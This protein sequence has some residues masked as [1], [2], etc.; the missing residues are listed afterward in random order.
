MR[1]F[2]QN[3]K[4][5]LILACFLILVILLVMEVRSFNRFMDLYYITQLLDGETTLT[6]IA[7]VEISLELREVADGHLRMSG[8]FL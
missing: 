5:S 4:K 7:T 2:K 6:D 3:K 1:W 8:S